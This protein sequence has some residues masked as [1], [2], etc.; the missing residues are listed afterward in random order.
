MNGMC[1]LNKMFQPIK[2]GNVEIK[3]RM[4]MSAMGTNF[5]IDGHLT[6][7]TYR[8]YEE[9]AKGGFGLI[10]LEATGVVPKGRAFHKFLGVWDDTLIPEYKKLISVVHKHDAKIFHQIYHAGRQADLRGI[11]L[12]AQAPTAIPCPKTG[13]LPDELSVDDIH[14]IVQAWGDAALRCK[15]AGFDGIEFHGGHGY[16]I[17]SFISQYTNKRTD[18]Y[19]GC[20]ENRLRFVRE[21]MEATRA[22]VGKDYPVCIRLSI[23]NSPGS[24]RVEELK[25]MAIYMEQVCGFDMVDIS[26]GNRNDGSQSI[27]PMYE[28]HGWNV[29]TAAAVAQVVNIPVMVVGRFNDPYFVESALH[30]PGIEMIAVGRGA[31]ADPCFPNKAREG[32]FE[33]IA[34]CIGCLQGCQGQLYGHNPIRCTVNPSVGFESTDDLTPAPVKKKVVVIG[35]GPGGMQA[36]RAAALK[37]HSVEL[38]EAKDVL[39]GNFLIAAYPPGKG[40]YASYIAYL[41]VALADLGV[42]VHL[43]HKVTADELIAMKPDSVIVATGGNIAR[44]PIKGI[45][46]ANVITAE[47]AL[48]SRKPIGQKVVV[49]GGGSVGAETANHLGW[50]AKDVT[51]VDMLPKI[52]A[53]ELPRIRVYLMEMLDKYKVKQLPST[54]IIEFNDKGV[55]ANV[56]GEEKLLE[57]DTIVLA[58]GYTPDTSLAD[59]LNAAGVKAVAIGDAVTVDNATA[60]SRQGYVAGLNA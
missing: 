56:A 19:G 41:K 58:F 17:H 45:D 30:T 22:K 9:R 2:I 15:E 6:E 48:L 24:I 39:G 4:A 25:A 53:E 38:F 26:S 44:P 32:K 52:A 27:R 3:N 37:G 50:L 51:V 28:P 36:A 13:A 54:K 34:T 40:E 23:D 43:N 49:A 16:L 42:K 14:E 12:I 29:S 1:M 21:I 60:A 59:A 11:G 20:F 55:L 33:Q 8:Y 46:G 18:E 47:D 10:I 31:V 5:G 35:G 7:Q 57:A